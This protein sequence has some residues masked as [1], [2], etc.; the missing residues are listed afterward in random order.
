MK[1]SLL[2]RRSLIQALS[3]CAAALPM[4][5]RAAWPDK[6]IRLV[7]PSAAGG[8]PDLICRIL[9]TELAKTLGMGVIIDNKPG[10]G[11]AIGIQEVTRAAPDGYTL[12]YANVGTLAINQSL[13]SKLPY[14][15]DKQLASIAL[16]GYVQNALVVGNNVPAKTVKE[17]IALAKSRPGK[18]T[19]GSA[20]NGTTGHLGGELFKNMTNT[21]ITH[22]PY[23]GSPQAIQDLIGG[24]VDLMFD[25]L[26]SILPHIKAG[27]VRV[28]GVSGARRSP[29]LPDVPTIAEAGVAGYETTAWGGIVAPAGTSREIIGKLNAEI[30][31]VLALP[32]VAER[33]NQLAFETTIAQ[34]DRLFERA[35]RERPLWAKVIQRSGAKVD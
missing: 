32:A 21:F 8:A 30:N 5:A 7:V 16:L 25:N 24:Q 15:A 19:M 4:L 29:A 27:R 3:V 31:K 14:D 18:L 1:S 34:P 12:G 33:Y 17:L 28:L 13:Y 35:L 23:R 20:G 10:A 26:S 11:G 6:P 9:G 22:V 2:H